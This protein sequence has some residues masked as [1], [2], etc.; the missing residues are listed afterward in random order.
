MA[1]AKSR[2][3]PISSQGSSS[4]SSKKRVE[5]RPDAMVWKLSELAQN[6]QNPKSEYRN[7]K[8][9][10]VKQTQTREIQTLNPNEPV[11]NIAR[12][13]HLSLFRISDFEFRIFVWVFCLGA[14][15]IS[16]RKCFRLREIIPVSCGSLDVD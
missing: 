7:P 15:S 2:H 13:D 9:T 6:F 3:L 14:P 1:K 5:E 11:W 8:Q 10:R 16:L 4:Q 12:L